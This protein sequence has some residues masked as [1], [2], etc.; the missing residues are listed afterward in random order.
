MAVSDPLVIFFAFAYAWA[1]L[2]F[3]PMVIFHAPPQWTILATLGPTLAAVVAQRVVAG[4]YRAF[5]IRTPWSRM[6]AATVIGVALMVLAYVV[7]P[8]VTTADPRK[9]HWGILT[10]F[11]V[12]NY[13]TLLGGPLFEEPGWRGFALPR[14]EARFGPLRASM[15]LALLWT[16]WHLPLFFYPGW[17]TAPLWIYVLIMIGVTFLLTFGTNLARFAVITPIA[18]HATFNTASRFLTGLF[19]GTA[20][21][22]IHIPFELVL[23]LCGLATAAVLI[24]ATRGQLGYRGSRD[25][26]H[27]PCKRL[28]V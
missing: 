16:G 13:S 11:A 19:A 4:D 1:W 17:I 8:S 12:Y 24:V 22:R 18:M 7:L 14:L 28:Q 20:G 27:I 26:D 2:V 23:A 6:L 15:L 10:S 25:V 5:R 9:L 3:V 21:P